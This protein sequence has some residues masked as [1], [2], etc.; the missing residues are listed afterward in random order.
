MQTIVLAR[1]VLAASLMFDVLVAHAE[2]IETPERVQVVR[3]GFSGPLS[4]PSAPIGIDALNG[5]QI[6]IDRLNQQG[7]ELDGKSLR[8]ETVVRDDQSDPQRGAEIAREMSAIGVSAVLGPINSGVA[9]GAARAYNDGQTP[10]LTAASNPRVT[11]PG[12]PYIFRI[13]ASDGDIGAKMA[14]Y[15]ARTLK[16]NSV[17]VIDDGSP[18]ADGLIDAFQRSARSLGL[19]V[20]PR[21]R[22]APG[23]DDATTAAVLR[24]I[25]DSQVEAVFIGAYSLHSA[26]LIKH[27]RMMKISRPVLGG[28][29][30]CSVVVAHAA[31]A[32]LGDNT[33]C[34][35]GGEWLTKATD[36]AVFAAGF[37]RK[38][39]RAPDVYA[40]SYFDGVMLLA[41]AIRSSGSIEGRQLMPALAR[42]RYK[43][44]TASYEFNAQHDL[45]ES[46]VTIL[47]F[48][49]GEM[50]PLASY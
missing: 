34:V 49:D 30:L 7:M 5:M 18:Y 28:D 11:Q 9:L 24:R 21:E 42:A 43:G 20:A 1:V 33:Y 39:G 2:V 29:A 13:V 8:F 36:G 17:A 4:G 26:R 10:A 22:I 19:Q 44:I 27:M 45:K 48:K 47:R 6:A 16:L 40:A 38:F 15:A 14:H 23:A 46:S 50:V 35:L 3:I 41:H 31:G 12:Q 25:R 32:A 37:Q